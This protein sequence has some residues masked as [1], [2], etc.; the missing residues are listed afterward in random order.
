MNNPFKPSVGAIMSADIAVPQ[1][2]KELK[3]YAKI[4]TTGQQPQ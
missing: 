1:H 4:L 2:E 3:F